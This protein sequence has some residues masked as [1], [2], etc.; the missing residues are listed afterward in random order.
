MPRFIKPEHKF[1]LGGDVMVRCASMVTSFHI[2]CKALK[3]VSCIVWA[4]MPVVPVPVDIELAKSMEIR[5]EIV[6]FYMNLFQRA[7]ALISASKMGLKPRISKNFDFQNSF[8]AIAL[9]HEA[10]G[11]D[12][13]IQIKVDQS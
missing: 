6:F 4:K 1:W 2:A 10:R 5:M 13:K 12:I 3:T 7:I 8:D 9:A 11:N